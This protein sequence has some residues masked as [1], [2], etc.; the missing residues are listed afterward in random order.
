[1]TRAR[2]RPGTGSAGTSAPGTPS[3]ATRCGSPS[4]CCCRPTAR[5]A[6]AGTGAPVR[7]QRVGV[8][9]TRRAGRRPHRALTA[10]GSLQAPRLAR[11]WG[12]HQGA[13]SDVNP[14]DRTPGSRDRPIPPG[15]VTSPVHVVPSVHEEF[16]L[17]DQT[18]RLEPDGV[19]RRHRLPARHGRP[20][21]GRDPG[22]RA[23]PPARHP[24]DDRER[25][26]RPPRRA[27]GPGQRAD[28][29]VRRGLPGQ[30]LL[31]R[32]R[33][34]RQGREPGPRAGQGALRRR[35]RQRAA[36]LRCPGERRRD[37][38]PDHPRRRH[39]RPRAGPRRP[40][41]PRHEAQ[42]QRQALQGQLVR[43]R[44]ADV[45]GRH[46]RRARARRSRTGPR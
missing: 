19:R 37:A 20:R 38:R 8:P 41:D 29:Q 42:L 45:P 34:G 46:G 3:P 1:M 11:R 4:R 39:P 14:L 22:R 44:P 13:A 24:R 23:R 31:R 30:A 6:L 17:L 35:L 2:A 16:A 36:A 12:H 40:P 10:V 9:G 28:Q 15:H 7:F 21:A 27:R 32:L 25:E 26:L 5:L 43:G 33:G 18:L